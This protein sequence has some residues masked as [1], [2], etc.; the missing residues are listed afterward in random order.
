MKTTNTKVILGVLWVLS[1]IGANL[2]LADE[3]VPVVNPG[4]V[5]SEKFEGRPGHMKLR[6]EKKQLKIDRE[7]LMADVKQ[8]GKGSPQAKID[9]Q[10]VR[11]DR[12]LIRQT[13]KELHMER[14]NG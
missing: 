14:G 13:R 3:G 6:E 9:R 5:H 2:A 7:K 4:V 12:E 1:A 11:K 10:Q 8:F